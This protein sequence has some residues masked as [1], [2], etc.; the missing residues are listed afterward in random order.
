MLKLDHSSKVGA[1]W[2]NDLLKHFED[3]AT[4]T[5]LYDVF[6]YDSPKARASNTKTKLGTLKTTSRCTRSLFGD[7]KL[8]FQHQRVE[9][10]FELRKEW[11]QD[12]RPWAM[13]GYHQRT[14]K[15]ETPRESPT[16]VGVSATPI[17][18][19]SQ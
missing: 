3:I 8:H 2:E 4:G 13:C 5:Q 11:L 14:P 15:D 12:I 17:P 9:E 19:C 6:A 1:F 16:E 10:D 18:Y 7:K